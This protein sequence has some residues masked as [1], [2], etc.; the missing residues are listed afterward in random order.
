[1]RGR[2]GGNGKG[3]E[4]QTEMEKDKVHKRTKKEEKRGGE[5]RRKER[6]IEE[7]RGKGRKGV[8]LP[9][10]SPTILGK[11]RYLLRFLPAVSQSDLSKEKDHQK[12]EKERKRKKK[13]KGGE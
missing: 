3:K 2:E 11:L 10:V 1:M 4:M 9:P 6:E 8:T 12:I 13:K 5:E 7:K